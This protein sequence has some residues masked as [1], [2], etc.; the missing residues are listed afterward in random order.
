MI[1]TKER[2]VYPSSFGL[3]PGKEYFRWEGNTSKFNST[4]KT[5]LGTM[6]HRGITELWKEEVPEA[7][8][9]FR[10]RKK[11]F[12]LLFSGKVDYFDPNLNSVRELKVVF[13]EFDEIPKSHL[14]Q[15]GIYA[16]LLS[17]DP[18]GA[19]LW[20]YM[21]FSGKLYSVEGVVLP[22]VGELDQRA[23]MFHR[24][25]NGELVLDP[26]P[27]ECS[28]C[29]TTECPRMPKGDNLALEGDDAK[30]DLRY[31]EVA[32]ELKALGVEKDFLKAQIMKRKN[33]GNYTFTHND[34]TFATKFCK[35]KST[36]YAVPKGIKEDY[37][38]HTEYE[39]VQVKEI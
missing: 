13:T 15:L 6:L 9:E 4:I 26:E 3:C 22:T 30:Y 11:G 27:G 16:D 37:K 32:K 34:R 8:V 23:E 25:L 12:G 18:L 36:Y 5:D 24:S 1:K 17:V 10:V 38:K 20:H 33:W 28:W 35:G 29:W 14:F 2:T 31:L 21:P 39:Y 19:E 7:E